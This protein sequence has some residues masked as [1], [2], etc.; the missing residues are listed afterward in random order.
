MKFYKNLVMALVVLIAMGVAGCQPEQ[1]CVVT[2]NSIVPAH[3]LPDEFSDVVSSAG[4]SNTFDA[5]TADGWYGFDPG[6]AQAAN[7][8]LYRLWWVRDSI[9]F[10][11][12]CAGDI[13]L[14]T[15][16]DVLAD[17]ALSGQ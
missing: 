9:S 1:E 11:P 6:V 7:V 8:G 14:V 12:S 17:Q 15:L 5:R 10:T 4:G 2:M 3:R 13:P 16:E